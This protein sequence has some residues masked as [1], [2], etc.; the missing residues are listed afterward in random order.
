MMG[1]TDIT[2][3]HLPLG[4]TT[5]ILNTSDGY[6]SFT[7]STLMG[8]DYSEAGLDNQEFFNQWYLNNE[9]V[10]V[11]AMSYDSQLTEMNNIMSTM[12]LAIAV[13]VGISLLVGGIGVMNIALVSMT[14]RIRKISIHKT[15]GAKDSM[16]RV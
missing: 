6:S 8:S 10:T 16:T 2:S 4:V 15:L 3:M 5:R 9:T 13:I 7:V 12:S 14:E 1:V 11:R